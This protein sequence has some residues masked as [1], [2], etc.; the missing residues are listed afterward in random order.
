MKYLI[1]CGPGIGDWI[2]IL[3]MARRIKKADKKAYITAV[4]TSNSERFGL[5]K[6]L[7]GLQT[8]I[9]EA[10][11]YSAKEKLH[12][13]RFFFQVG[14]KKY[15]YGFVLQYTDSIYTSEWPNRIINIA[16]KKTCGI[17][18]SNKPNIKYDYEIIRESGIRIT[19]YTMRML[20]EVGIGQHEDYTKENYFNKELINSAKDSL[21]LPISHKGLIALVLGT[22]PVG[23]II[24]G[25][26]HSNPSKNWPYENWISLALLFENSGYNVVLLGG[27]KEAVEL[28]QNVHISQI[29][30][31]IIN[32]S[33]KCS[34]V[35][36]LAIILN[37]EITIGADTGLMHCAGAL[38]VTTLTLFGCTDYREYLPYGK[39]SH[40][41]KAQCKY[42]PCFGTD[43]A[44]KCNTYEC[45][46]NIEVKKVFDYSTALILNKK[47]V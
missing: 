6:E 16:A 40:Y 17:K 43:R 33:G 42:A 41:I 9:D 13:L 2:M 46:K 39:N 38:G 4:M 8:D 32:V 30:N 35:E 10:V 36:S 29:N 27:K 24:D 21:S 45:M 19:D 14:V 31:R 22:A 28:Q 47:D 34:I 15:D 7:Q 12:L 18:L 37:S 1:Y 5:T 11:Y 23:G 20:D 26:R 3:P 44:L 25:I